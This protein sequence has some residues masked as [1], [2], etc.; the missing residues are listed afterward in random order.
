MKKDSSKSS[1]GKG[2][3]E[4]RK[5]VHFKRE[6][7]SVPFNERKMTADSLTSKKTEQPQD[8]SELLEVPAFNKIKS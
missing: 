3:V 5:S 7:D 1:L 6:V 2:S 8:N 4:H